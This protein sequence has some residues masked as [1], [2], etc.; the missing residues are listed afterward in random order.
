MTPSNKTRVRAPFALLLALPWYIL[1][2][3]VIWAQSSWHV[4]GVQTISIII[5]LLAYIFSIYCV[6]V[7]LVMCFVIIITG[8]KFFK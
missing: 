4:G 2:K 6:A 1:H 8:D 5:L 7:G 3:V